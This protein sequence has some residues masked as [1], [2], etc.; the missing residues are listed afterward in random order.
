MFRS[1][2]IRV[3]DL[4]LK[5]IYRRI[6]TAL[7]V[8]FYTKEAIRLGRDNDGGYV[9]LKKQKPYKYLLSFGIANDVSFEQDFVRQN[10]S[11]K[12]YCFDPSITEL[13][14]HIAGAVFYRKGITGKTCGDYLDI[15]QV[16]SLVNEP[17]LS[18]PKNNSENVL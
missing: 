6:V 11:C 15:S 3:R 18:D 16:L 17:E 8:D 12:V 9:V 14:S 1:F 10:P 2:C 7:T 4:L 13:P 5:P